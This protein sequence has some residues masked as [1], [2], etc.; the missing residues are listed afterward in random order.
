MNFGPYRDLQELGRGGMGVV[1]KATDSR[2]GRVVALKRISGSAASD[3]RARLLLVREAGATAQ[4]QHPNI[5]R[6]Y[7]VGQEN[8]VLYIVMEYLDGVPLNRLIRPPN[9]LS[10]PESLTIVI[11]L[12]DALDYAHRNG[13]VH[14]DVKPA[15][16]VILRDKSVKVLDFGITAACQ[17]STSPSA[18]RAGTPFYMSPEQVNGQPVDGRSDIWSAGITLLELLTGRLPYSG[19]SSTSVFEQILQSP[20][21]QV[22]LES[23][24]SQDLNR[25]LALAL[26]K[27]RESRYS[28][29]AEFA[30]DLR[31]LLPVMESWRST[32][33]SR[34][35][36]I[37][38]DDHATL[39]QLP[40]AMDAQ[41]RPNDNKSIGGIAAAVLPL[42][43]LQQL[44]AGESVEARSRKYIPPSLN[45]KRKPDRSIVMKSLKTKSDW[46]WFTRAPILVIVVSIW[47]LLVRPGGT[48]A[49]S[50][51][52]LIA[53]I[54]T[55]GLLVTGVIAFFSSAPLCRVCLL[56]MSLRSQWLNYPTSKAES[57]YAQRD[58]L[59]ALK[60]G[61]WEDATKLFTIL[62]T[63][64][65]GSFEK[66]QRLTLTFYECSTCYEQSARL[67]SFISA[68]TPRW[69]IEQIWIQHSQYME[70]RAG[71]GTKGFLRIVLSAPKRL[72]DIMRRAK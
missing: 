71:E 14:R 21:P 66:H 62:G 37:N 17:M 19:P 42:E 29:A 52:V 45:L 33:P 22:A 18:V 55:L 6:V 24:F 2:D 49:T 53:V 13:I 65:R 50:R 70:I 40:Q 44:N 3:Q 64:F 43:S 39:D 72:V 27:Q 5:V 46:N 63:P 12:C 68:A 58:C 9:L 8:A 1:Y 59:A 54:L 48:E 69:P 20:V 30:E 61:A 23:P 60:A 57:V 51:Y 56:P 26:S 4:L 15:N 10:A 31:K 16:I 67:V 35:V 36:V 41:L 7:D 11:Q 32:F 25:A 34:E 47:Y 38:L 28:S